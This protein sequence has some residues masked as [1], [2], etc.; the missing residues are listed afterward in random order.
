VWRGWRIETPGYVSSFSSV[1]YG[2]LIH[3]L[4]AFGK[5][6]YGSNK[7]SAIITVIMLGGRTTIF[8]TTDAVDE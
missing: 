7:I 2:Q 4:K 8:K 3:S 1:A 6:T 5:L